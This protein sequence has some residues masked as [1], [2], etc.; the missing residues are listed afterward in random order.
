MTVT[1]SAQDVID[2]RCS[3]HTFPFSNSA[4]VDFNTILRSGL[5]DVEVA[6]G[7]TL[8]SEIATV[9]QSYY[10]TVSS[11]MTVSLSLSEQGEIDFYCIGRTQWEPI[12]ETAT[13]SDDSFSNCKQIC[14]MNE[15]LFKRKY[16]LQFLHQFTLPIK[17]CY[18]FQM[19][20]YRHVVSI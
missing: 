2:M 1:C 5:E 17:P 16:F 11:T 20:V 18:H 14:S 4:T 19:S 9:S 15:F 8:Y 12:F 13:V 10:S 3:I 7:I 6:Q